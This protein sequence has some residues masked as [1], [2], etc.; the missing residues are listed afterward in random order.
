MHLGDIEVLYIHAGN[1]YLDGGAMFGVVPKPL[2]E[3]NSPPD[4]R[5]RI[6]LAANSL[7]VRSSNKNILIETGN[8]TKWTSKLHDIYGIS[9]GDPLIENLSAAGVLPDQIGMV[10]NT[11]LH[12]DHAGG[13]TKLVNNKA[14]P[15]FPNATYI[16]QSAELAHAANPT[17]R[18]RASYFEKTFF[19]SSNPANGDSFPATAKS[20]QAFR[21]SAFQATT[22]TSEPSKLPVAGRPFS[23]LPTSFRR[24][25][26]CPFRGSWPMTFTLCRRSKP[27][28]NGYR[29][30]SRKAGS[31][32][33]AT[34]RTFPPQ[35]FTSGKTKLNSNP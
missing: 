32:Y 5:N 21:P 27:S 1:F 20:P 7:L 31:L 23:S 2:W 12:F 18:D 29:P 8:G 3:K 17:E 34:T 14:V 28:E 9:E 11:Y 30:S 13:N 26:T 16:V 19:P 6:R 22:P 24:V 25:T 15:T 4:S 33:L 10:I 35:R